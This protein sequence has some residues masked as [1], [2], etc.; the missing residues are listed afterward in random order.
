MF[1]EMCFGVVGI[2]ERHRT[3]VLY[4]D[5]DDLEVS[6]SIDEMA[7]NKCMSSRNVEAGTKP[8][9]SNIPEDDQQEVSKSGDS[10]RFFRNPQTSGMFQSLN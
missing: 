4:S 9:P 1:C 10:S 8:T 2:G 7:P 5:V 6:K 3:I